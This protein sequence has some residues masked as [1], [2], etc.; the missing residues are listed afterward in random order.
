LD[1]LV[2]GL[3][4]VAVGSFL[5][6]CIDRIPAGL[7]LVSPPSHCPSCQTRLRFA[8]LAPVVS[9]VALRGRCRYCSA[10]IG[11]RSPIVELTTGMLFMLIWTAYGPSYQGFALMAYASLFLVVFVT[12]LES[13][14][15]PNLVVL[16]GFVA[17]F[18]VA[19][20]WPELG[21]AR[22]A[23]GAGAGFGLMLALYLIPGAVVG[24]G[25]VKLAAVIG[26]ASGFPL[27]VLALGLAFV[28]GGSAAMALMASGRRKRTDHIPFGPFMAVSA[29]ITLVWGH[30][31]LDWYLDRF[32]PF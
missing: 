31:I 15:I 6:V 19:S 18:A 17:A 25:D 8:D 12:D 9:Y 3:V 23:V 29:L 16:T 21:P 26:A 1:L 20:F 32:W 13:Q 11:A 5:N 24:E 22:A 4:G 7:S 28:L 27:V 10:R 14:I 2:V 30:A